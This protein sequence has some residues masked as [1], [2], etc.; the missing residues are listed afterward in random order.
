MVVLVGGTHEVVANGCWVVAG[1][2]RQWRNEARLKPARG[3]GAMR[4]F[5][6]LMARL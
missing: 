1:K 5:N 4:H 3:G 2:W 6:V